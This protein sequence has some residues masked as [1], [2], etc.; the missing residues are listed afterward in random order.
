VFEANATIHAQW[1]QIRTVTFNPQ[2][3]E[4]SPTSAQTGSNGRLTLTA[5]PTPTRAGFTFTG[6]FTISSIPAGSVGNREYWARWLTITYTLTYNLN[7]GEFPATPVTTFTVENDMIVLP[8][9]T[10]YG[11]HF[12][13]WYT[14]A[15]FTSSPVANI[16][17]GSIGNRVYF[18]RWEIIT[19]RITFFVGT[20]IFAQIYV[21]HG[22]V[23]GNFTFLDAH[24]VAVDMFLDSSHTAPPT[25]LNA[26]IHADTVLFATSTFG[27]HVT[28]TYNT[29]G[30]IETEN[31]A[32]NSTLDNL[33]TPIILGYRFEGWY[34]DAEFTRPVLAT[35]R[36]T[37]NTTIYARFSADNDRNIWRWLTW[38]IVGVSGLAALVIVALILKKRKRGRG[39]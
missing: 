38:V 37:S 19:Y 12:R 9:P 5:L 29:R 25:A 28:L 24:G 31:L 14:N 6:W 22:A 36:L 35:D 18:A 32:Y 13:G 16:P 11:F 39:K 4:V 3:G 7:G 27:I 20:E 2:D 17:A 33:R 26:P 23:L 8:V 10:R 1:S 21:P 15:N 34:Y 30:A